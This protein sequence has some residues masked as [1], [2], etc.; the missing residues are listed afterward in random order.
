MAVILR[1]TDW[2]GSG[3]CLSWYLDVVVNETPEKPN[4]SGRRGGVQIGLE[5]HAHVECFGRREVHGAC[6]ID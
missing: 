3:P 2:Y 4:V 5:H 6:N 1:G